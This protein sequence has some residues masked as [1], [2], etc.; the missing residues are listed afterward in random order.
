MT[1]YPQSIQSFC[2][3][4]VYFRGSISKR[5]MKSYII[6]SV[7]LTE[8]TSLS[9]WNLQF[10]VFFFDLL[11][12]NYIVSTSGQIRLRLARDQNAG[13]IVPMGKDAFFSGR[14]AISTR[15]SRHCDTRTRRHSSWPCSQCVCVSRCGGVWWLGVELNSIKLFG[16]SDLCWCELGYKA[17]ISPCYWRTGSPLSFGGQ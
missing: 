14:S 13:G 6:F 2:F 15:P 11:W 10:I 17:A 7:Y 1:C 9:G 4:S 3:Y 12:Y 16:K 8:C 5:R